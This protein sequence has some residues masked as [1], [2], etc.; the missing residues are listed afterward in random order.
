MYLQA[1]RK[2]RCEAAEEDKEEDTSYGDGDVDAPRE[3]RSNKMRLLFIRRICVLAAL[4]DVLVCE[5]FVEVAM[6]RTDVGVARTSCTAALKSAAEALQDG[7]P[8]GQ[9]L[10]HDTERSRPPSER[11]VTPSV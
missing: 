6:S 7:V 3:A 10:R 1:P 9:G 8:I 4:A 11:R 2:S 5:A